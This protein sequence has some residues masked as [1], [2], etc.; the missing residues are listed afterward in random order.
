MK[1]HEHDPSLEE[2]VNSGVGP[3]QV[4]SG[5]QLNT[6][7]HGLDMDW[8]RLSIK[9]HENLA[10]FGRFWPF[11]TLPIHVQSMCTWIST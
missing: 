3:V 8:S 11:L 10:A 6:A 1:D 2:I 7:P 4:Q 9:K 5:D